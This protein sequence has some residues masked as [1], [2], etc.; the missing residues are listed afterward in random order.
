VD[1]KLIFFKIYEEWF[2]QFEKKNNI[3]QKQKMK[4]L[5][6]ERTLTFI[7]IKNAIF[8]YLIS[9]T[10]LYIYRSCFYVIAKPY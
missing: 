8:L 5:I 6:K 2:P 7:E 3:F 9:K 10:V 4:Y 1:K